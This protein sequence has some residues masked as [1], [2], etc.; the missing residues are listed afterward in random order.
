[1]HSIGFGQSTIKGKVNDSKYG[2][3]L[4]GANVVVKGTT[5][6]NITDYDGFFEVKTTSDFPLTLVF[7]YLGYIDKEIQVSSPDEKVD[8]KLDENSIAIDVVEVK[9]SR[10]SEETK[11]SPLTIESMDLLAV[12]E[13]PASNFYEGLGALKGVDLTT[14]SL[15][16]QV[17]N[18]RGFNSTS[19]VRSLQIIDGVDNQAPGLNFSLGNF[20]GSSELDILKVDIIVGASSAY[21]GPNA[22][23]GVIS[24]QTKNPFFQKGLSAYV[25]AGERS[26]REGAFRYAEALRNSEGFDWLAYKV[27]AQFFQANDWE[28]NNFD[29]VFD[30]DT[31]IDNVGGYDAVNIYG[32]EYKSV[33]DQEGA[34]PWNANTKGVGVYH[35]RGYKESDLVNYETNNLK[36]NASVHFRLDPS[37]TFESP[38]LILSSSFSTGST[39]YQGDNRFA[40]KDIKFFQNRIEFRKKD[41]YFLRAYMTVDDAGNSYDP[42]FTALTMQQNS[43]DD[44]QWNTAYINHW[45]ENIV[46]MMD[47]MGYP[48]LTDSLDMNGNIVIGP[49]GTP[50]KTFDFSAQRNW[51]RD[52]QGNLTAWHQESQNI[53]N[54]A[55]VGEDFTTDFFVP[56]TPEFEEEFKRITTTPSG[57]PSGG[58]LLIDHSALYH[59]HGEYDFTPNALKSL[60]VGANSRL[61]RPNSEGTIFIDSADVVI[62]NFEYGVYAGAEKGLIENLDLS[63]TIRMDKNQN[64]GYLFSPAASLVF[65]PGENTYL[66]ASFS[67]AIRN[68]TL[69][70]QYLDFDVGPATLRGNLDGVQDLV[71]VESFQ[72]YLEFLFDPPNRPSLDSFDIA[73]IRPEKVKTFELGYRTTLFERLYVDAGYYFSS[74]TDFIGYNIGLNVNLSSGFPTGVKAFRYSANSKN[75]VTT[76][77]FSMG[78]NYFLGSYFKVNGNYSWNK[79]N[80]DIDD[81]IIPAFNTPEHKFNLGFSG[82]NLPFKALGNDKKLGFNFNY[83]WIDS[84]IFEGSPQ[85]TG[86][87]NSYALL[88]GQVSIIFENINTTFKFGA[89]NLL[90][91]KVFQTYGG[92]RVGRLAYFSI[93]Y[94]F[95]KKLN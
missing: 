39:I 35:R 63:A 2:D 1:M 26:L 3:P 48:Q 56:G 25:K 92:P 57:D 52:N 21:Y 13:T 61:Y 16:F 41:K 15:G 53:A 33:F 66:R 5:E 37:K 54:S 18:T 68:P 22:F 51:I 11:K 65:T 77:G 40:L 8:I 87:I 59:V 10:I 7:S 70:D 20:L 83:K 94:D 32:D 64:F 55:Q 81:P 4:I 17:I 31:G 85:F 12:K 67:S 88:D 76:Q 46:P 6:G 95:Q 19:P 45:T 60:K 9:A 75:V 44:E 27:N 78:L 29:P 30:T 38:E 72:N 58:T 86:N 82:R 71:T 49:L 89:S 36:T 23:N 80:T 84:F 50:L 74:Y 73:P 62:S 24:M 93:L 34:L 91:N 69:S 90:N 42:Y 14:A 28:A 43:K 79:L 47:A